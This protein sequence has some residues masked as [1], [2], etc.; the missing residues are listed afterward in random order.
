MEHHKDVFFLTLSIVSK[1][2]ETQLKAKYVSYLIFTRKSFKW[3][4]TDFTT[5][6]VNSPL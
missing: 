2:I 3:N 1:F 5:S 6:E 4:K